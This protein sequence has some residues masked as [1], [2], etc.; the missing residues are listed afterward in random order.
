MF[1]KFIDFIKFYKNNRKDWSTDRRIVVF[2]SDDWGSI[3][4][5]SR[6]IYDYLLKKGYPVD[7]RPFERFDSIATK[8][9]F[10]HLFDV[11]TKH[12]DCVGKNPQLTINTIIANPDFQKIENDKFERY[13]YEIFLE[14]IKKYGNSSFKCWQEGIASGLLFPQLHGREHLNVFSWMES[15][16]NQ[17]SIERDVFRFGMMGIPNK[18]YPSLGNIHQI[19]FDNDFSQENVMKFHENALKNAQDIFKDIF[20]FHSES[21][22]A[23]VYTWNEFIESVLKNIKVKYL[24]GGRY[25]NLP[26]KKSVIKH[27]SGEQSSSSGLKYLIRNAYFEPS[28]ILDINKRE[29]ALEK[30]K[31]QTEIAFLLNKPLIVSMHRL[32]FIGRIFEENRTSN[33]KLLDNY[34]KWLIKNHPSVEF[35]NTVELG[36]LI[37]YENSHS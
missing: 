6:E 18:E 27:F 2:E 12:K 28:S 36:K 15:V 31:R 34:L 22:I 21:F 8:D 3:R 29:F 35:L 5:P 4:M 7:V 16:K 11:L 13:H 19:T 30:L 9:D 10:Y 17:K 24:Q 20:G 26:L 33:L 25:Q 1:N 23:P 14:T 37:Q 32:N